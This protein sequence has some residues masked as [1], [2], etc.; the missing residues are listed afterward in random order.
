[1]SHRLLAVLAA[2]LS[3]A[4]VSAQVVAPAAP[5]S[6]DSAWEAGLTWGDGPPALPKGVKMAK[7]SG[8]PAQPG[9]FVARLKLPPGFVLPPHV[10]GGD[11]NVTV[12]AGVVH[13]GR[14]EKL[15]KAATRRLTAGA[16][17]LTPAGVAH[18]SH[19]PD[20]AILQI[21]GVGPFTVRYVDPK[22]DPRGAPAN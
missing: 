11:E 14:G 7:L 8:D 3:S 1:M 6:A 10:H 16:Y 22:D 2:V 21:H 12:V 17:G 13:S 5:A 19:S 20:G 18:F 9:P 15:D 4:V